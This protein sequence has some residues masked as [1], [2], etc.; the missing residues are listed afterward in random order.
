MTEAR[1][2]SALGA[3]DGGGASIVAGFA[4]L[5]AVLAMYVAPRGDWVYLSALSAVLF[6]LLLHSGWRLSQAAVPTPAVLALILFAI[7]AMAS[8]IWGAAPGRA[9][10]SGGVMLLLVL[11]TTVAADTVARFGPI[12]ARRSSLAVL[13]AFLIGLAFLTIET[14]T[15]F[16]IERLV[17]NAVPGLIRETDRHLNIVNDELMTIDASNIK[18]HMAQAALL[19]WPVALIAS[20]YWNGRTGALIGTAIVIL[21]I[22]ASVLTR[23]DSS[24]LAL[25][26]SL[27]AFLASRLSFRWT[28]R[29]VALLWLILT[30]LIVPIMLWEF[31]AKLYQQ[32]WMEASGR[33]RLVIWGYSAEQTLKSPWLGIGAGSGKFLDARRADAVT[34]PG[35]KFQLRTADHQHDFYLQTW[36]EMGVLGALALCA[37]GLIALRRIERMPSAIRAFVLA[38]FVSAMFMVST[39]YGLWQEWFEASIA[40]TAVVLAVAIGLAAPDAFDLPQ[41]K[42][43]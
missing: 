43:I 30:L 12:A 19:L 9:I 18:R 28:W 16:G 20:N 2:D 41:H 24:I 8:E 23:H 38:S 1:T 21:T 26:F 10:K 39:S 37:A 36:Y 3:A 33:H 14:V 6:G 27:A 7:L 31:H 17:M 34:V 35:E 22:V 15:H 25:V 13:A 29:I 5:V 40:M 42:A 32:T 4:M 11:L